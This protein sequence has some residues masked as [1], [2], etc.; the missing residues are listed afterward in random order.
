MKYYYNGKLIRTSK[1]TAY[2][3]AA[4]NAETGKILGCSSTAEGAEKNIRRMISGAEEFIGNCRN[5]I[6]AIEVAKRRWYI[7]RDGR[8]AYKVT[9]E[10][11]QTAEHFQSMIDKSTAWIEKIQQTCKVVEIERGE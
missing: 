7:C 5:A 6:F 11:G 8:R 1:N 3:Y 10:P 9:I 2:R 4:I